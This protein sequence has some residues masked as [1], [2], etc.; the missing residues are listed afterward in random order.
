MSRL[1]ITL[2]SFSICVNALTSSQEEN[3]KTPRLVVVSHGNS[4]GYGKT[5]N[6]CCNNTQCEKFAN[7]SS[8]ECQSILDV[9]KEINGCQT[10][11]IKVKELNTALFVCVG[12][13]IIVIII[14]I[15]SCEVIRRKQIND[16]KN[17]KGDNGDTSD[18]MDDNVLGVKVNVEQ[19]ND[20]LEDTAANSNGEV[21]I[22]RT[23]GI[24]QHGH[25]F[26]E[27][28]TEITGK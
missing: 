15:V 13:C 16:L 1:T 14:I 17:G 21:A 18:G 3:Y 6:V 4:A 10:C 19:D 7:S 8:I 23:K 11:Q 12:C 27:F 22:R 20:N 5:A 2:L 9:M 26:S 25:N 28:N 24:E